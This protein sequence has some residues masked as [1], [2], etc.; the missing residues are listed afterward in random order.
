MASNERH[1]LLYLVY[2]VHKIRSRERKHLLDPEVTKTEMADWGRGQPLILK[3][4]FLFLDLQSQRMLIWNNYWVSSLIWLST[5]LFTSCEYCEWNISIESLDIPRD[6]AVRPGLF[7]SCDINWCAIPGGCGIK[8]TWFPL[9]PFMLFD[10]V[11][12]FPGICV[13]TGAP[14]WDAAWQKG[15]EFRL[16][17]TRAACSS[18]SIKR[19]SFIISDFSV[20]FRVERRP[21]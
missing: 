6:W 1:L 18:C 20:S 8:F 16:K 14:S 17:R 7:T 13:E 19:K 3:V 5:R 12:V 4:V 21:W 10:C 9:A 2:S 11:L 15:A